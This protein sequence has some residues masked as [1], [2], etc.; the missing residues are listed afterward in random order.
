MAL[1]QH[2]V[3]LEEIFGYKRQICPLTNIPLTYTKEIP[4]YYITDQEIDSVSTGFKKAKFEDISIKCALEDI[5]AIIFHKKLSIPSICLYDGIVLIQW[6]D[7][8]IENEVEMKIQ[9]GKD[10]TIVFWNDRIAFSYPKQINDIYNQ[11]ITSKTLQNSI[12]KSF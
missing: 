1:N 7:G 2:D 11:M 10:C 6:D 4:V 12:N 8:H 3:A 9:L 5:L